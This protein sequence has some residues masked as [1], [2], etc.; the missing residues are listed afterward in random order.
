MPAG[1][2]ERPWII[3]MDMTGRPDPVHTESVEQLRPIYYNGEGG[4][5]P[6][7]ALECV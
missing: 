1:L 5:P 3:E 6:L 2:T 4:N 7:A